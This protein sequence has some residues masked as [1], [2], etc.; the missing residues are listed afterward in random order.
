MNENTLE[1]LELLVFYIVAYAGEGK[2]HAY[3]ALAL[4]E[5]GDFKGA[6]EFMEK[7]DASISKAHNYQT[8]MIQ[9]EIN[10]EKSVSTMLFVHAQDH[11][12]ISLSERDLIKKMIKQNERI[13]KLEKFLN[14]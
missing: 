4:S 11:L 5:N 9:K 1:N 14:L 2:A 6:L 7:C 3:K 10:S 12:M 8:T 13:Y